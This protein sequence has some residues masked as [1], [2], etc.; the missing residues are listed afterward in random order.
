MIGILSGGTGTPKLIYGLKEIS[1]DFFVVVNTA[2]DVWISGNKICPDIDSVI[3]ALSDLIDTQK[4]WGVKDDTFITHERLKALGFDERMM[5]GDLD[6]ATHI[7]RSNLLR[8]GKSL[9][10][11]T[12]ILRRRFGIKQEVYPMCNEDVSTLIETT[13]GIMHFQDFW[14]GRKGEPD[15]RRIIFRGIERAKMPEEVEEMLKSCDK[16][17]IGPSNPVT[18][19]GPIISVKGYTEIL[20]KKKVVAVSP[21]IGS[22]A[23]SGPAAKFMKALGYEVSPAG[24]AEIYKDFIDVLIVDE[25]DS[26]YEIDFVEVVKANTVME[27]KEDAIELANFLLSL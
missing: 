10:E 17:I 8:S 7:L 21:I 5:I 18:S 4:W 1:E 20:K 22:R 13:E 25:R 11:A 15:V 9:V 19:I 12:K 14:V 24:V 26:N 6:R 2:E 27:D 16:V 23:F 3:Y